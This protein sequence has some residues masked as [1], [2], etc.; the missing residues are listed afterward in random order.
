MSVTPNWGEIGTSSRAV[1]Q[2]L[3]QSLFWFKSGLVQ[4]L[5]WFKSVW[6]QIYFGSKVFGSK[7][8]CLKAMLAFVLFQSSILQWKLL[9]VIMDTVIIQ[10]M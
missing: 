5:F 8:C 10:F 3:V 9:N 1:G 7:F 2:F 4:N 6:F